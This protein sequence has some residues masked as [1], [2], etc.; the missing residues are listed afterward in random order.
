MQQS[1]QLTY[2]HV[3]SH[4]FRLLEQMHI[5]SFDIHLQLGFLQ[6]FITQK[7]CRNQWIQFT[8]SEKRHCRQ[9]EAHKQNRT[10]RRY[11][12]LLWGTRRHRDTFEEVRRHAGQFV[13]N[14]EAD[15]D[16][17][18]TLRNGGIEE[19]TWRPHGRCNLDAQRDKVPVSQS[20]YQV[21]KNNMT[22]FIRLQFRILWLFKR[23]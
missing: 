2:K 23:I 10:D 15:K 21:N 3:N 6:L 14:G 5:Q 22:H 19:E 13:M 11:K 16:A 1:T 17:R 9:N 20:V 7:R 18:Q 8:E 4:L 12:E